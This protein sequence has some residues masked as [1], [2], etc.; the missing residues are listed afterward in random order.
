MS[1]VCDVFERRGLLVKHMA[2]QLSDIVA[3]VEERPKRAREDY[4]AD[5]GKAFKCR[6]C[7][8]K[9][10]VYAWLQKH[11]EKQLTR[12]AMK[13]QDVSGSDGEAEQEEQDKREFVCY[14]CQRVLKSKTWPTRHKYEP[15]SNTNSEDS[16]VAKQSVTVACSICRKQY[17]YRWLP[18]RIPTKHLGHDESLRPQPR[19]KP[20]RKVVRAEAQ[21]QSEVSESLESAGRD[22][23]ERPPK[24]LRVVRHTEG[25][26][27]MDNVCGGNSSVYKQWCSLVWHTRTPRQ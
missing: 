6:W 26:E 1:H 7:A 19:V 17:H 4:G 13:P 20:K 2:Q 5:D 21:A 16:D 23:G 8:I 10:T 27:G 25:K 14:R 15:T 9:Y 3:A 22:N 11:T 12:G 18:Q 24:R